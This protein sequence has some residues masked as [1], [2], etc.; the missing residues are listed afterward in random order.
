MLS[1]KALKIAAALLGRLRANARIPDDPFARSGSLLVGRT[2]LTGNDAGS[3]LDTQ[4]AAASRE[5]RR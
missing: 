1:E 2:D 3:L 4:R 5:C